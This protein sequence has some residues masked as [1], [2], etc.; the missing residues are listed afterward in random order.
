MNDKI[1]LLDCTLRDGAYIVDAE[2]GAVTIGGIIRQ[3]Q[4]ANV[5]VI[6]CGWLKN[7]PHKIGTTFYHEPNDLVQ[8]IKHKKVTVRY[9]WR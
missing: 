5:K 4:E 1:Q 7:E 6:E 9:M 3:L 8:Y 2:F